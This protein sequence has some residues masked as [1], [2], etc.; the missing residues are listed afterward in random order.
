[1]FLREYQEALLE[2]K[3]SK[4]L[5]LPKETTKELESLV[6]ETKKFSSRFWRCRCLITI[7]VC[8]EFFQ[9]VLFA[10]VALNLPFYTYCI[11]F[12]IDDLLSFVLW[13]LCIFKIA[14]YCNATFVSHSHHSYESNRNDVK[15]TY[16]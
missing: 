12:I 2:R 6:K 3:K 14:R 15:S 9:L 11:K 5:E 4:N 10:M 7:Y 16:L 1:M 13:Y 8:I